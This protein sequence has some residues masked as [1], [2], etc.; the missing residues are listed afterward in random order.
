M[1]I[2]DIKNEII[3]CLTETCIPEDDCPTVADEI[4]KVVEPSIKAVNTTSA[5]D[6]D[7]LLLAAK[8]EHKKCADACK[9][10]E[11]DQ[12]PTEFR[13]AQAE[14]E[15]WCRVNLTDRGI[16]MVINATSGEPRG[17][18]IVVAGKKF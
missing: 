3:N 11:L 1:N 4:I 15:R 12:D 7:A 2:N 5:P 17:L 13:K 8:V 10:H 18:F 6:Y 14:W 9:A 16:N